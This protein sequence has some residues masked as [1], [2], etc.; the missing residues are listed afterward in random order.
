[1][2]A[3]QLLTHLFNAG[4][5]ISIIAT[6]LALGMSYRVAELV[7]PLRRVWLVALV[8]LVNSVLVPAAAWG[9]GKALPID[10]S[11]VTGMTLAAIGAA[12]AAGLKATQLARRADLPLA[13]SLVVVLQ[14]ANLVAVPLWA[15]QVVSGASISASSILGNL[16]LLVLVPLA[17]GLLARARYTAHAATWQV[18]LTKVSNLAL[19]L[20]LVAGISVNW[21]AIV[22]LLGSWVLLA[23][24]LT[25]IVAVALGGVV[26]RADPETR[27][28]TGLVSG[29]RFGSLGLI[30]IGT[31]LH[32]NADY[33]GPAIVFSLVDL[34]IVLLLSVEIGHRSPDPMNSPGAPMPAAGGAGTRSRSP[35]VRRATG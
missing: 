7:A 1:M 22:S 5:A 9:I 20:A 23:S 18:E 25:A 28:T 21:Q 33:L 17:L 3:D 29:L 12:S 10:A 24:A 14:F 15:G 30:I 35:S 34:I 8:I 2:T 31:Q 19:A 4:V 11:A 16:L 26:G 27:T 32:G 13:V 6:V